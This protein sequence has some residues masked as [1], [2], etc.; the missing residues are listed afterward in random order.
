MPLIHFGTGNP[1]LLPL[2]AQAGGHV[3]GI[4]WRIDLQS[5]WQSVGH[6]RA[7]QG[8]L[9]PLTLLANRDTIA[10][11]ANEVLDAAAHRPGHIFNL[12]HGVLQQTSVDN[13][14]YL[15]DFVHEKSSRS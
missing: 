2:M 5:A 3:M 12:G 4:D 6:D 15:V 11:R 7:V 13:V 8:N 9:D 14:R 1:S 10:A